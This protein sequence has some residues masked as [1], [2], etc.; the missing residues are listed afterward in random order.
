[1][2]PES[3]NRE[4]FFLFLH[5]LGK[6]KPLF[7]WEGNVNRIFISWDS[8]TGDLGIFLYIVLYPYNIWLSALYFACISNIYYSDDEWTILIWLFAELLH[9]CASLFLSE[10]SSLLIKA[11]EEVTCG[12]L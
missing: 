7:I 4:K 8:F 9:L 6:L 2:K 5:V 12:L 3:H 11:S 10:I 1:M